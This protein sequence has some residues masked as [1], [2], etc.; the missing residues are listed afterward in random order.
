L[1]LKHLTTHKALKRLANMNEY[2][3]ARFRAH[4]KGKD[5]ATHIAAARNL[6]R[7]NSKADPTYFYRE[8]AKLINQGKKIKRIT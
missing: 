5:A 8:A 1:S 4:F 7:N 3:S 2:Q 6:K